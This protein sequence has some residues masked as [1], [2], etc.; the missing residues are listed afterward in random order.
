M[1]LIGELI[2]LCGCDDRSGRKTSKMCQKVALILSHCY[3]VSDN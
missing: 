1:S 2:S 3:D